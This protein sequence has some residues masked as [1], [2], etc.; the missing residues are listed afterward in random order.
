[1]LCPGM[2]MGP[3]RTLVA[4][5]LAR[6]WNLQDGQET[7]QL[8]LGPHSE[9]GCLAFSPDSRL[10][11]WADDHGID[12]SIHLLDV[13]TWKEVHRLKGHRGSVTCLAFSEDGKLLASGSD[14]D[15]ALIWDISAVK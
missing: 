1:M 4:F 14:D 9:V 8:K 11:A 12:T 15:T 5:V 7:R 2:G 13:A 3:L 6:L 10:L